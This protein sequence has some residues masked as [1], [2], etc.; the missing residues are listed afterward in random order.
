MAGGKPAYLP[1]VLSAVEALLDER[2]HRRGVHC[3]PQL[4]TPLGLV[5]GPLVQALGITSGHHVF[6]QG[7]RAHATI[8]RAVKLVLGNVGGPSLVSPTKRP[9]VTPANVPMASAPMRPPT[10]GSRCTLSAVSPPTRAR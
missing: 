1:G 8:G 10:P 6:G 5:N 7:W 4:S 3:S 2:G 9:S